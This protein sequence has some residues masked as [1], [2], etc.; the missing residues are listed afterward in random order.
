MYDMRFVSSILLMLF[1]L[2]CSNKSN[3]ELL[4][5]EWKMEGF[6][7]SK[8]DTSVGERQREVMESFNNKD[9]GLVLKFAADKSLQTVIDANGR[10]FDM[11]GTYSLADEG[12]TLVV[13][14][15]EDQIEVDEERSSIVFLTSD[16]L[17][18]QVE[19]GVIIVYSKN[20]G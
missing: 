13:Q 3:E 17:K 14:M 2:A 20:P 4:V 7:L 15:E 6:D 10:K 16:T 19:Q 18:L 12:N 11:R 9:G 5:G 8:A 1:L